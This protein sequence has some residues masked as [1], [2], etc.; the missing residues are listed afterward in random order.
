MHYSNRNAGEVEKLHPMVAD[1]VEKVLI[2]AEQQ[3]LDILITDSLRTNEEQTKLYNQGRTTAG[4]IVTNAKAGQSLHNYGLAIDIVPIINKKLAYGDY[5]TYEAFAAIAKKYGFVW[6]GDWQGFKDTPH[7]EYTQ[8]HDW[9]YFYNGGTL[10]P[11]EPTLSEWQNL[12]RNNAMN[13]L[14]TNGERPLDQMTRVEYWE[15]QRK[16]EE[17]LDRKFS[18]KR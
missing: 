7:F 2:E 15:S 6:G 1:L 5:R 10:K 17:Y 11:M 3:G 12:A 14:W 8:G 18:T 16:F 13:K 4:N 9:Q